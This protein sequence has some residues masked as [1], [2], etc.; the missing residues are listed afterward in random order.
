MN[1]TLS[2]FMVL[3]IG[4]FVAASFGQYA[5]GSYLGIIQNNALSADKGINAISGVHSCKN[6]DSIAIRPIKKWGSD[7]I[8]KCIRNQSGSVQHYTLYDSTAEGRDTFPL[9]LDA[10]ETSFPL[11]CCSL[12][13]GCVIDSTLYIR[14][15]K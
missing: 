14:Q 2:K 11:P 9:Y 1:F 3:L 4:V 10:H 15:H 12:I 6:A 5:Y 13:T 8:L 7:Y